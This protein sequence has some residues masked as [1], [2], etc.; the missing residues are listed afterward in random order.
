MK[1]ISS[2]SDGYRRAGPDLRLRGRKRHNPFSVSKQRV[3]DLLVT[4][5]LYDSHL[6]SKS[7]RSIADNLQMMR[8][9]S[10]HDLLRRRRVTTNI[11]G[12]PASIEGEFSIALTNLTLKEIHRRTS[13]ERRNESVRRPRVQFHRQ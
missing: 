13:N 7:S 2:D 5:R 12:D 11:D 1:S 8:T 9:H 10:E 6:S 4:H 3:H